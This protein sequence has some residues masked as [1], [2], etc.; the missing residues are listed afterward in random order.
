MEYAVAEFT[1]LLGEEGQEGEIISKVETA[2]SNGSE[3]M[4]DFRAKKVPGDYAEITDRSTAISL[5]ALAE[6][7]LD[8]IFLM[9]DYGDETAQQWLNELTS[10]S[11][12]ASITAIQEGNIYFT[13]RSVFAFNS[14]IATQ[15]GANLVVDSLRSKSK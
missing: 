14:P 12:W 2:I 4:K 1:K 5:E 13:D 10:N 8:H 3:K 7:N 11:V 9:T 6:Y 15:Y